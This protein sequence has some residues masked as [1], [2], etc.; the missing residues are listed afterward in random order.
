MTVEAARRDETGAGRARAP[1]HGEM[2][3]S[4]APLLE[5]SSGN[6]TMVCR[7]VWSAERVMH[8]RHAFRQGPRS[9][10]S[11]AR[12]FEVLD[13]AHPVARAS[14]RAALATDHVIVA[15]AFTGVGA[16]VL[17]VTRRS[18]LRAFLPAGVMT[19]VVLALAAL[20]A[21]EA[22]RSA[23]L[24]AIAGGDERV[25][26]L[27]FDRTLAMLGDA[28][29]RARL[30]RTLEVYAD[31]RTP[32]PQCTWTPLPEGTPLPPARRAMHEVSDLLRCEPAPHPRAVALCARLVSEGASSPLFS[33][34]AVAL[35]AELRRIRYHAT[36][37]LSI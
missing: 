10:L 24:S 13:Q 4:A 31:M 3:Q 37:T 9:R 20:A 26:V 14:D 15:I 27:E 7:E 19:T 1:I 29:Y 30:A 35:D 22:V 5:V 25:G 6:Y 8:R 2:H 16:A 18:A 34:D 21:G 36:T 32:S 33:G 17:E 11:A 12:A 28:R 23:V